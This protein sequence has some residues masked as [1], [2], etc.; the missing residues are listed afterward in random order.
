[1]T[2]ARLR[3]LAGKAV[4]ERASKEKPEIKQVCQTS[5]LGCTYVPFDLAQAH[6]LVSRFHLSGQDLARG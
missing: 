6:D 3:S 2:E 1:M 5:Q 4:K